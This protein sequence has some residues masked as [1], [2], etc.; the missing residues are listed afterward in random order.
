[1]MCRFNLTYKVTSEIWRLTLLLT[2]SF[3]KV[4]PIIYRP[5]SN[6]QREHKIR[7][8]SHTHSKGKG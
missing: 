6:T 1:M 2:P 8:Y 5:K 4:L 7:L 3:S